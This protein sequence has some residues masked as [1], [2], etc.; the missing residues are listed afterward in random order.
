M[1]DVNTDSL[2]EM[3]THWGFDW[4]GLL[5]FAAADEIDRL[6][7]ELPTGNRVVVN[8]D[9]LPGPDQMAEGGAPRQGAY[10]RGW[11]DCLA[12]IRAAAEGQLG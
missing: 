9:E 10:N 7:A 6:R 12:A 3:A 1:S 11:S 5:T 2:R 4:Q 8:L